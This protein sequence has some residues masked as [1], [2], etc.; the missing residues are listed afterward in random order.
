MAGADNDS[1]ATQLYEEEAT[2][3]ISSEEESNGLTPIP[4]AYRPTGAAVTAEVITRK[5]F[6][7]R[8]WL[9]APLTLCTF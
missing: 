1:A 5:V 4:K 2:P 6:S 8:T 3:E 9:S 7:R